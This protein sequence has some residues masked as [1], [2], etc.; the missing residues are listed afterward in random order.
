M[1]NQMCESP[2]NVLAVSRKSDARTYDYV[3]KA[4]L[5]EYNFKI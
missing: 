4:V 2:L 1:A 3:V 5:V